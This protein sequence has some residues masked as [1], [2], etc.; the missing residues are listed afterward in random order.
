MKISSFFH[1]LCLSFIKSWWCKMSWFHLGPQKLQLSSQI[2]MLNLGRHHQRCKI[3]CPNYCLV[4]TLWF[5]NINQFSSAFIHWAILS[6]YWLYYPNVKS[7]FLHHF[8]HFVF[9]SYHQCTFSNQWN[10]FT[11][12]EFAWTRASFAHI[13]FHSWLHMW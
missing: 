4:L 10:S 13:C 12:F 8:F 9:D 3:S 2:Q 11:A 7:F 6:I 5:C 1:F